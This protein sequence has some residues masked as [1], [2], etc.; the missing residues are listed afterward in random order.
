MQAIDQLGTL[1]AEI[2]NSSLGFADCLSKLAEVVREGQLI[3]APQDHGCDAA[4]V[5]RIVLVLPVKRALSV[6]PEWID[7]A[8]VAPTFCQH[9]A[10]QAA[11]STMLFQTVDQFSCV[12]CSE[13]RKMQIK[14]LDGVERV[15]QLT[16]ENDLVGKQDTDGP[17]HAL[18]RVDPDGEDRL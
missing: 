14:G 9:L 12:S 17:V 5:Y 4:T 18:R 16:I 6:G 2:L 7:D 10:E 11:I 15:G 13:L 3:A 1:L 8:D